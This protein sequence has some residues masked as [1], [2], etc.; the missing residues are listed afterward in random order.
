MA[1]S[2]PL[3]LTADVTKQEDGKTAVA[4]TWDDIGWYTSD[5]NT[6]ATFGPVIKH[7]F[8]YRHSSDGGTWSDYSE[9]TMLGTAKGSA[10]TTVMELPATANTH[11][12]QVVTVKT[13]VTADDPDTTG[14]DE[15]ATNPQTSEVSQIDVIGP[16]TLTNGLEY[17][18]MELGVDYTVDEA[19]DADV[20]VVTPGTGELNFNSQSATESVT[21][22]LS[23]ES[24]GETLSHTFPVEIKASGSA[25]SVAD[26][27]SDQRVDKQRRTKKVDVSEVFSDPTNQTLTYSAESSKQAVADHLRRFF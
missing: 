24:S 19:P 15:S 9:V 26:T 6:D 16:Q 21:V 14:V 5:E 22:G 11:S 8:E 20:L 7:K 12:I 13:T 18:L 10:S 4:L 23:Q 17:T 2:P 25:P 3:G 27:I 1:P